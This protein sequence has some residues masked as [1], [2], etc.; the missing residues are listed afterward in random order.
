VRFKV[1]VDEYSMALRSVKY[2]ILFMIL[3]FMTLWM[4]EVLSGLRIHAVQYVMV[5]AAMCMFYLLELSLAEHIGF[6]WA[7]CIASL[8]VCG[9]VAGYCKTVL[10]TGGRAA[11]VGGVLSLLYAYLYMLLVNQGYALLAGSMGLFVVLAAV[12]YLTRNVDWS[13]EKEAEVVT[14]S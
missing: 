2:D 10:Q 9:L 7:Y 13:G 4:F 12:M 6:L 14:A 1:M 5:G 11:V 3:V 8:M